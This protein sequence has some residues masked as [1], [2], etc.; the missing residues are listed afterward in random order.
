MARRQGAAARTPGADRW[1]AR[2]LGERQASP[3]AAFHPGICPLGW[4]ARCAGPLAPTR[5]GRQGRLK[6]GQGGLAPGAGRLAGLAH[7]LARPRAVEGGTAHQT[8]PAL[9]LVYA[10]RLR[11]SVLCVLAH[12]ANKYG[13]SS[14]LGKQRCC[15]AAMF[16]MHDGKEHNPLHR[17]RTQLWPLGR[18]VRRTGQRAMV[19]KTLEE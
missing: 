10:I 6:L 11:L 7:A 1:R 15:G 17:P 16:L 19:G 2:A 4:S 13:P 14:R 12:D 3:G 8:A 5:R 18:V 9:L